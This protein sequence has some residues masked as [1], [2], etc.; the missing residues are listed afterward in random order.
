VFKDG[1]PIH[2]LYKR[3]PVCCTDDQRSHEIVRS[4]LGE[5]DKEENHR[6]DTGDCDHF[7]VS[8]QNSVTAQ[9]NNDG[10]SKEI[11]IYIEEL[12]IFLQDFESEVEE[13]VKM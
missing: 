6:N 10:E 11:M 8:E 3:V 12:W 13:E 4:V 5:R 1:I 9:G 7:S 2:Q